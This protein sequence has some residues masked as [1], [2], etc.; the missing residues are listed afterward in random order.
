MSAEDLAKFMDACTDPTA[1]C[2]HASGILKKRGFQE[3]KENAI[4][5]KLPEKGFFIRS[6]KSIIAYNIGGYKSAVITAA[7]SDSPAIKL[8]ENKEKQTDLYSLLNY[9]NYTGGLAGTQQGRDLKLVGNVIYEDENGK[10]QL[11]HMDSKRPIG[12]IPYPEVTTDPKSALT[13]EID[14]EKMKIILG[15]S[16]K[17]PLNELLSELSG[18]DKDK[19]VSSDL[20]LVDAKPTGV[21]GDFLTSARL[22]NLCSSYACLNGFVSSKPNGTVN[23]L[24]VYDNEENGSHT[25]NGALGDFLERFLRT[26]TTKAGIDLNVFKRNSY[27]VSAD[28]AHSTHPNYS[29]YVEP[30]HPLNIGGGVILKG[31]GQNTTSLNLTGFNIIKRAAQKTKVLA[32]VGSGKNK[33]GSGG[34]T[35]GPKMEMLHGIRTTDIGVSMWAMHSYRETMGVADIKRHVKIIKALYENYEEIRQ[36]SGDENEIVETNEEEEEKVEESTETKVDANE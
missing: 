27:I 36:R 26:L 5:E 7:H 24:A 6:W 19:I 30:K 33:S 21:F 13:P 9:A 14:R 29:G 28:A 31:L 34:G 16:G 2:I 10:I 22:D 17:K 1:F 12:F 15:T 11:K 18:V 4:P 25:F 32:Q 8:K 3:L 20:Y 23:V 35:I